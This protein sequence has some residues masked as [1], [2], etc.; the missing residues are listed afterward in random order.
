MNNNIDINIFSSISC[1]NRNN[2][3][4]KFCEGLNKDKINN[5]LKPYTN[6]EFDKDS[7]YFQKNEYFL[8]NEDYIINDIS[9][10]DCAINSIENNYEGFKYEGDKN[11]C[12]LFKSGDTD[13]KIINKL[14]NYSVKTFLKSRNTIDIDNIEDQLYSKNYFTEYNNYGYMP[15]DLIK[16]IGVENEDQCMN[17]CIKNLNECKSIL[18]A[19]QPKKCTF[20]KNKIIKNKKEINNNYDIYTVKKNKLSENIN[21]INNLRSDYLKN[22]VENNKNINSSELSNSDKNTNGFVD[23]YYCNLN[24]DQC[25]LDYKLRN[26]YIKNIDE[27]ENTNIQ[28]P[29]LYDCSGF[30]STNPFCTKEYN[31]TNDDLD[32]KSD[33]FNDYTDCFNKKKEG[34]IN[35]FKNIYNKECKKKFGNEYNFDD[36]IYNLNNVV[37]CNNNMERVKCKM[38]LNSDNL[39]LEKFSN[40][41][42][43]DF[44]NYYFMYIFLFISFIMIINFLILLFV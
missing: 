13:N 29:I 10:E 12:M 36:N 9:K 40:N 27:E 11:K 1:N 28:K 34:N 20:Y 32:L 24:N 21:I 37:Q 44:S 7:S 8:E 19:E 23:S 33:I 18:Y 25:V 39:I 17:Y 42:G 26:E 38:N 30:Y 43:N 14:E 6:N 16:E 3:D 22:S 41:E 15:N 2:Y 31:P 35:K 4:K 5:F